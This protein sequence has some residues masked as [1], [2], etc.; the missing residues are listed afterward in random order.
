M[1][2]AISARIPSG[3]TLHC[4]DSGFGLYQIQVPA[5][6]ISQEFL[7]TLNSITGVQAVQ[8]PR[9]VTRRNNPNDPLFA[10]QNYLNTI[11]AP[12]F[13]ARNTG[14][15]NRRGDTLVVALIDDGMD[16]MHPDL[17]P[18]MWFNR[19]EISWNGIDD[20]ANGYVDDYRG[21]R[22]Q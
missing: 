17:K 3:T 4:L 10:A 8:Q 16:T 2:H 5:E 12:Q 22:F 13:W 15:V 20:D 11:Y 9:R 1:A 18:N 7:R 6:R 19:N 14:G 21:W